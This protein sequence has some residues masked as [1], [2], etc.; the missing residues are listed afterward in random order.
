VIDTLV[1]VTRLTFAKAT[2]RAEQSSIDSNTGQTGLSHCVTINAI[3]SCKSGEGP[4]VVQRD[5]R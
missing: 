5:G 1:E 3:G 2:E 4:A